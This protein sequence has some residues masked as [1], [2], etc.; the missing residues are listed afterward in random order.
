MPEILSDN[1]HSWLPLLDS[2]NV[3]GLPAF[4]AFGHIELHGLPFLQAAKSASLNSGEM[5]EDILAS[6]TADEAIA[7]GIVKPLY[8]S[9]FHLIF[10]FPFFELC[11]EESLRVRGGDAGWR[12]RLSTADESN[13]ADTDY[14][15]AEETTRKAESVPIGDHRIVGLMR[16]GTVPVM[17][18]FFMVVA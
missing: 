18:I 9:L 1:G 10:L 16:C 11:L 14:T 8:C 4:R 5:H 13:L 3:L 17:V 15:Q 6:L 2:L 12:Y 7:F